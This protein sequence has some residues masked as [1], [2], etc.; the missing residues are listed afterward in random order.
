MDETVDPSFWVK[1]KKVLP[2]RKPW[3]PRA[4][5]KKLGT[6]TIGTQGKKRK[7]RKGGFRSKMAEMKRL[8]KKN[9]SKK[10]DP[11]AVEIFAKDDMT[12]EKYVVET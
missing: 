3:K 11:F 2:K 1:K 4:R 8:A 12:G 9:K 10:K 7:P 6:K 5:K